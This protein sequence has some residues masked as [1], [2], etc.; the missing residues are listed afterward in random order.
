VYDAQDKKIGRMRINVGM[1]GVI[2]AWKITELLHD[3]RVVPERDAAEAELA[4]AGDAGAD[5]DTLADTTPEEFDRF[6]ALTDR[7]L[8]VPKKELDEK[9]REAT[10][11]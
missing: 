6:E 3:P 11:D 10:T 5:L 1:A 7:L 2:P 4:K 8:R 9:L